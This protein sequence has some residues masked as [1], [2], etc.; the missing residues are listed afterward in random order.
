MQRPGQCSNPDRSIR[1]FMPVGMRENLNSSTSL[2]VLDY[3]YIRHYR[4]K[5]ETHPVEGGQALPIVVSYLYVCVEMVQNILDIRVF[6]IFS[7]GSEIEH[8]VSRNRLPYLPHNTA[9]KS[10]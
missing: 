9:T 8:I 4:E 6:L 2:P 3:I 1:Y 5:F 7:G 10:W